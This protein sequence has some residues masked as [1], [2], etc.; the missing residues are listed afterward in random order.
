[1][2][3]LK[4]I[5]ENIGK[6]FEEYKKTNDARFEELKKGTGN[7]GEYEAKLAKIEEDLQKKEKQLSDLEAKMNRPGFAGASFDDQLK[8]DH[9]KAFDAFVRKGVTDGLADLQ[10]KAVQVGVDADGG[11]AVPEEMSRTIYSMLE[12]DSPMRAVCDVRT[13]GTEDVKQLVDIGG[14][15][16]G[17]VAETTA[18][19]LTNSPQLAQVTPTFGEIYA[20]PAATQK[21]IDDVFFDVEGW[22]ATSIEREFAKQ[23]NTAFTT[24]NGTN[25]PKGL[26]AA[27]MATTADDT[28]VFG[29]FQYLATGVAA[30][31]PATNPADLL[32]D[33]VTAVKSRYYGNAR[34][35]M[36]RQTLAT[37]RKW[38]DSQNNYL[39]QPGLQSGEP[40]SILGFPYTYN[41]D[42]P[43]I[44]ANAL[45]IAFGDFREAYIILDRVGVRLL[46]D[47][48]TN[49]PYV[50]FYATKRVGNMILNSEA[51]KFVKCEA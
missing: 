44:G 34:F 13:V 5:L 22:L 29:T 47:P 32:I 6:S 21:A 46:R 26:L 42:F 33:L 31:M 9:K 25:K 18:R 10:L 30:G 2:P 15:T 41:D 12:A 19:P 48:Y 49:K 27:T 7:A 8:A 11:Y 4:E 50:N 35:M 36:N 24:G 51:V 16:S 3:E 23:E 45:C 40:N 1:M 14:V 28:R 43:S 20:M 37:I 17:W 39:W 38:K